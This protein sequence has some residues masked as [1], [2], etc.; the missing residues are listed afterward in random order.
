MP[1][2]SL[3]GSIA[4]VFLVDRDEYEAYCDDEEYEF[5]GGF[6]DVSPVVRDVPYDDHWF[7]VVES[8]SH[9]ITVEWSQVVD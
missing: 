6:T 2:V 4:R 5:Y 7:L 3:Q 8:N 1:D 9:P